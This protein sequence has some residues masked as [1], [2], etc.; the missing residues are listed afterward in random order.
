MS[1]VTSAITEPTL[2]DAI[3]PGNWF[4]ALSAMPQL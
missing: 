2:I 1:I 3:V 4:L